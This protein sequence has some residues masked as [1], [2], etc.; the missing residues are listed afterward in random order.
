MFKGIRSIALVVLLVPTVALGQEE[1]WSCPASDKVAVLARAPGWI[2]QDTLS[3]TPFEAPVLR[4]ERMRTVNLGPLAGCQYRVENSGLLRIY[5]RAKC[6][7]GKGIW[8]PQGP[9]IV[10]ES[11]NPADCTL[12]CKPV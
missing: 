11:A 7:A 10:C 6:E 1:E 5:K 8:K 4:F 3:Y 2:S 12:R 9:D